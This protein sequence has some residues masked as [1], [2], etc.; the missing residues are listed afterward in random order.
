MTRVVEQPSG[1][2]NMGQSFGACSSAP[3]LWTKVRYAHYGTNI[4][5]RPRSIVIG[6]PELSWWRA[7]FRLGLTNTA[8]TE[9]AA[10]T[11]YKYWGQLPGFTQV[12]GA[13]YLGG[14]RLRTQVPS[15]LKNSAG[16]IHSCQWGTFI[17]DLSY[18]MA[19]AS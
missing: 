12:T 19:H 7:E 5:F 11:S 15:I 16:E 18:D 9:Y 8:G 13:W 10:A 4:L 6:N 17:I 1:S 14:F 3:Y 2:H